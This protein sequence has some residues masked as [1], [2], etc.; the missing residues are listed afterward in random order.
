M[1]EK[2]KGFEPAMAEL[3][4]ILAK[5]GDE[6]TSLEESLKLYARA[7]ELISLCSESL[8][9]AEVKVREIDL[10]I[11]DALGEDAEA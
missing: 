9:E 5:M 8:R 10:K 11:E 7:A 3:E 4:A 1:A 6:G 2:L